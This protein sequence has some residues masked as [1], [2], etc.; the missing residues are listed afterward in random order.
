[1]ISFL[2]INESKTKELFKTKS[3]Y[4]K[5]DCPGKIAIFSFIKCPLYL[6]NYQ[7]CNSVKLFI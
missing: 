2:S 4:F 7:Y 1:M 5:K 6:T 3:S